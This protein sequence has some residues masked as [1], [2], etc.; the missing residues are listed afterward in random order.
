[1]KASWPYF[2]FLDAFWPLSSHHS[3]VQVLRWRC[4]DG[5]DARR[6]FTTKE[7]AEKVLQ[8]AAFD[9][10]NWPRRAEDMLYPGSLQNDNVVSRVTKV[11]ASRRHLLVGFLPL[12]PSVWTVQPRTESSSS[13]HIQD[14]SRLLHLP[15]TWEC[16]RSLY[17]MLLASYTIGYC[18]DPKDRAGKWEKLNSTTR[19]PAT[20]CIGFRAWEGQLKVRRRT[21]SAVAHSCLN[22][23]VETV[24]TCVL[25]GRWYVFG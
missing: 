6:G 12:L 8:L 10:M 19:G 20:T 25:R 23:I 17:W 14:T 3:H 18:L 7:T 24:E 11:A 21:A 16:P 2:L 22:Y 13:S 1:M 5:D 9:N 15:W 4:I